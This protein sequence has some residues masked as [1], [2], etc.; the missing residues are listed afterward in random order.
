MKVTELAQQ[1]TRFVEIKRN[2]NIKAYEDLKE[3]YFVE[4]HAYNNMAKIDPL[5]KKGSIVPFSHDWRKKGKPYYYI[6]WG[7][8]RSFAIGN[9][10]KPSSKARHERILSTGIKDNYK[11]ANVK[12]K[13]TDWELVLFT[14]YEPLFQTI[15]VNLKE[16]SQFEKFTQRFTDKYEG[17]VR[18]TTAI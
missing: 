6:Y 15:R 16:L 18:L 13:A 9:P 2:E 12:K 3:R 7:V 1:T 4:W 11:V 17:Q 10:K 14:K 5:I 8:L